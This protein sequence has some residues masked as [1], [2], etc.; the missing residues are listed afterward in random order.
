MQQHENDRSAKKD[1]DKATAL[2]GLACKKPARPT[3]CLTIED[4]LA[5]KEGEISKSEKNALLFHLDSCHE[6]YE[7]WLTL[8]SQNQIITIN[9]SWFKTAVGFSLVVLLITPLYYYSQNSNES[10]VY[11]ETVLNQNK[12]YYKGF[13]AL[14]EKTTKSSSS[15]PTQDISLDEN[16]RNPY[17]QIGQIGHQIYR[18]C[19]QLGVLD[20]YVSADELSKVISIESEVRQSSNELLILYI[21]IV[22][23][24]AST[25]D[26]DKI[27][28][29][30]N[31][32]RELAIR[33]KT[34]PSSSPV[35]N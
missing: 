20:E 1:S 24:L 26:Q 6:C 23:I 16:S 14:N 22:K 17:F 2:L 19:N 21:D 32:L 7:K 29:S 12:L 15:T 5:F 31:E 13:I 25:K 8:S 10:A 18:R 33:F 3:K 34:Q 9:S 4:L 28:N 35:T 27:N 11:Q 30:C